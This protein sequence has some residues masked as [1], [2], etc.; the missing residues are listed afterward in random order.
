[1]PY[2]ITRKPLDVEWGDEREFTFNRM[3]QVPSAAVKADVDLRIVNAH[4]AVGVYTSANNLAPF[5]QIIPAHIAA[6]FALSNYSVDYSITRRQIELAIQFEGD[7]GSGSQD[8]PIVIE[9]EE[10]DSEDAVIEFLTSL[11]GFDGF[12]VDT[13]G[14]VDRSDDESV[15]GLNDQNRP[16][17]TIEEVNEPAY[18][19]RFSR[20]SRSDDDA[21]FS[22]FR[23]TI[24]TQAIEK[25]NYILPAATRHTYVSVRTPGSTSIRN[26]RNFNNDNRHGIRFANNIV[27]DK[28]EIFVTEGTITRVVIYDAVGNIVFGKDAMPCVSSSNCSITWDLRNT[29]GRYVANGTYLVAVETKDQNGR[30]RRHAAM[31]GVKR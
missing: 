27:S 13:T 8:D 18:S 16:T 1:M 20:S 31:L 2:Q 11:V 10:F 21:T 15:L 23:V 22:H 19:S 4:S 17:I 14:L 26:Q 30:M 28:A 12:G 3:V 7:E 9:D 29:A 25:D 24:V 6:N 5:A